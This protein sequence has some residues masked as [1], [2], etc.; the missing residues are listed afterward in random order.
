MMITELQGLNIAVLEGINPIQV[1]FIWLPSITTREEAV[2]DA[3]L[4]I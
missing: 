1:H 4:Y 3:D 2:V